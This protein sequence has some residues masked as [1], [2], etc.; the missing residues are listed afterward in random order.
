VRS[1]TLHAALTA[2]AEEAAASLAAERAHGAELPYDVVQAGRSSRGGTPLY[3]Y[4]PMTGEFILD[5]V[6]ALR[7]LDTYAPAV[8]ALAAIDGL[9]HYLRAR[10]RRGVPVDRRSCA[11]LA[12]FVFLSELFDEATEFELPAER[13]R[14]T[15]AK[16]EAVVFAEASQTTFL[17]VARG[18]EI[19][20]SELELG[21][22]L[23]LIRAEAIDDGPPDPV[24][25]GAPEEEPSV[26]VA[27][28]VQATP[29]EPGVLEEARNVLAGL[30]EALTLFGDACVA[31]DPAG[32]MRVDDGPWQ[33]VVLGRHSFGRGLLRIAPLQ[34]D[35]L[36]AFCSLVARRAPR[37]GELAWALARFRMGC[38]REHR[39]EGLTDHLLALR[40]LLEPEG[41]ESGR[42][43]GR[44]AAICATP[45]D[46]AELAERVADVVA[47]ERAVMG[48][49]EPADRDGELLADELVGHLR[50][51]LRD[52]VCGHLDPD[53]QGLAD[54]LIGEA[55][56]EEMD[57]ELEFEA[58]DEQVGAE[59]ELADDDYSEEDAEGDGWSE[60]D[61]PE[62]WSEEDAAPDEWSEEALA[63]EDFSEE[64][65]ADLADLAP[66]EFSEEPIALVSDE[67]IESAH[68]SELPADGEHHSEEDETVDGRGSD[69][70]P[71]DDVAR[72]PASEEQTVDERGSEPATRSP[73]P[74]R[75]TRR[76]SSPKP[77]RAATRT[78]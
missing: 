54:R 39:W 77:G 40:A 44:L 22:G 8:R 63:Q 4:R 18:V 36:R 51:L 64:D 72:E 75:T 2:F 74:R 41:L 49:L 46:R 23:A 43:P 25:P 61:A 47:L 30:V 3:C 65:L 15:Y 20:S 35:E 34:E 28:S 76:R 31:V 50:A 45:D 5:R 38:E 68:E 67:Q 66:Q 21:G 56:A 71:V 17:A 69:R 62:H 53:L 26:L 60:E 42:L 55:A 70:E 10:G 16:F 37:G 57:A 58:L 48:G 52:V 19:G 14:R 7:G 12:L 6:D 1:R 32:W 11:E 27:L 59:P 9:G 73:K 24:L 33:V 78:R 29:G 13:L